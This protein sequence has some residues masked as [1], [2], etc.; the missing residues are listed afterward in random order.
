MRKRR[1]NFLRYNPRLRAFARQLRKH[2]TLGEVLLWKQLKRRALGVEFHRQVP[3]DEYIV[4]FYCHELMLAVEVD[5]SGHEH[6]DIHKRDTKR[7]AR[8]EALGVRFL[9]FR[10][11]SVRGNIG[12]VLQTIRDWIEDHADEGEQI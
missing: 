8:L 2:G 4:D 11:V 7:Q 1:R 9:R 3:I 10:E 5:G 6:E 12:G